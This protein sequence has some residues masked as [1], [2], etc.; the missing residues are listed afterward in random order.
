MGELE[1]D[2]G[3]GRCEKN[4]ALVGTDQQLKL[5]QPGKT[6]RD[7]LAD[8]GDWVE[9]L[10]QKK[11]IQGYLKDFLFEPGL[12]D[13]RIEKLSGG[14][15]SRLLL[16]REFA[17]RSNLMVLDEPNNDID[18]ETM[19]LMK[20]VIA[21]YDGTVLNDSHDDACLER[22]VTAVVGLDGWGPRD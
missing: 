12:A 11:H 4:L 2:D 1:P 20:E 21:D 13:A 6:V 22:T 9:V 5:L 19:D 18:M 15:K 10:G 14:E 17:R 8:G 3:T 16:A 7:I